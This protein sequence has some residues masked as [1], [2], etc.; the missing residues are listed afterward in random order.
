MTRTVEHT[1]LHDGYRMHVREAG[2]WDGPTVV[3]LHGLASDSDTWTPLL[4]SAADRG[5]RVV[6]PDLLGHGRSDK[7]RTG[8]Y[9]LPAFSAALH[10]LHR[11][12]DLRRPTYVGHSFGGAVAMH[13][14]HHHPQ[15]VGGLTLIA[16]GGLGRGVHPILRAA[17][18]PGADRVL[19]AVL[20]ARTR[21]V[22][23]YPGF[24][25]ALRLRPEAV[26]NLARIGR[27]ISG[28]DSRRAF[29]ATLR[30]V[31]APGGQRGSM[32]Q[33]RYFEHAL[34][35]LILWSEHDPVIPVAH[36]HDLHAHLPGSRLELFAGT[37][38]EPHRRHH[39]RLADLLVEFCA[40]GYAPTSTAE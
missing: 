6:A 13:Y 18:V 21:H 36:A 33:M 14:A 15:D 38:H 10:D 3:L 31:I 5:L 9:T 7:P 8:Y 32:I 40:A 30:H 11:A 25:R 28:R 24:Q 23:A 12:L 39:A 34:P 4:H 37:S 16:A 19:G 35:T 26:E 2:P 20:N 17:A 1:V 27:N 22:W 29:F